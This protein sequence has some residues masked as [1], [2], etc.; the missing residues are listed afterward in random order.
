MMTIYQKMDANGNVVETQEVPQS[1]LTSDCW[2][3]QFRGIEAC[4]DCEYLKKPD[5]GGGLTLMGIIGAEHLE[6]FGY[7]YPK[8][9]YM[10]GKQA[11]EEAGCFYKLLRDADR[12]T[13]MWSVKRYYDR[14][15]RDIRVK[16]EAEAT[17]ERSLDDLF[18]Y[19]EISGNWYLHEKSGW[20]RPEDNICGCQATTR[21]GAAYRHEVYQS[22]LGDT[23]YY[24]HQHCIVA[25][26][27]SSTQ[28]G[29]RGL[30]NGIYLDACGWRTVTTKKMLN[31]YAS[32]YSIWSDRGKW[33]VREGW[34][35]NQDAQKLPFHDGMMLPLL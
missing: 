7:D 30:D 19:E 13:G 3:V 25:K 32:G 11:I 26:I 20:H 28:R 6:R 34:W 2:M 27:T 35:H 12:Y 31:E 15:L 8:I 4:V 22:G 33:W 29:L 16:R 18:P 17:R 10:F 24:L 5:C 23:C 1:A 9:V 14:I 21:G